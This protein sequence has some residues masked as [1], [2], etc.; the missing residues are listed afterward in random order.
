MVRISSEDN[1]DIPINEIRNVPTQVNTNRQ[2][3][4]RNDERKPSIEHKIMPHTLRDPQN[5]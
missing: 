2:L 1:E 3:T 5:I 4:E